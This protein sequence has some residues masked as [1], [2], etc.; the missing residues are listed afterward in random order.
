M[1]LKGF[2]VAV[3]QKSLQYVICRELTI[4]SDYLSFFQELY[5]TL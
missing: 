5:L 3:V 2:I 1:F 4:I